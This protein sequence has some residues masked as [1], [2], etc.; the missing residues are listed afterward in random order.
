MK[1]IIALAVIMSIIVLFFIPTTMA[2]PT[3]IITDYELYPEILMPGDSAMLTLT[4][5]NA[6]STYTRTTASTSGSTTT[7]TVKTVGAT[8]NNIWIL[9]AEKDDHEIRA[10]QNYEDVGDIAPGSSLTI[11]FELL[12]DEE[13]AEGLYFP[14]VKIDVQSY[15]DVQYPIPVRVS[16]DTVD[17]ITSEVSSKLSISG[18]TEI[19]LTAINNGKSQVEGVIVAPNDVTGIDV[20]PDNVFIGELEAGGSQDVSFSIKPSEIGEQ[21]LSFNISFK[22]GD[23]PHY[24]ILDLPIEVIET[25][26]VAPIFTGVISSI[27]KGSSSRVTLEVYN[28]KT[29]TITGVLVA[30][31]SDATIIPSKYFIGSMEP[32]D[33]FSA[34]FDVYTDNLDYGD[35]SLG[36]KV[37]FK[38]GTDYFET[39]LESITFSVVSGEGSSYQ[40]AN[41]GSSQ[42]DSE[43]P[44]MPSLTVCIVTIVIIIILAAV[45]I[46]IFT[47]WKKRRKDK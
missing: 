12:V 28:A 37:L 13:M 44:Q 43:M 1:K 18:S 11:T 5:T 41:Q 46:I 3:I 17:L 15:E 25:L 2:D 40:S 23:N 22:N 16:S 42:S 26:D 45:G 10:R 47:K 24:K 35:Y 14:V 9:A 21:N 29:E 19:T 4:I 39:P 7:T 6:E 32:D 20:V 27:K 31:V 8:I 38:Q 36:F 34:T 30:P 33:V